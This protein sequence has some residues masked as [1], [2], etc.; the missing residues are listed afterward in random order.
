MAEKITARKVV[1]IYASVFVGDFQYRVYENGTVEVWTCSNFG[2]E[3]AFHP[4]EEDEDEFKMVQ[5]IGLK[6]LRG[7][8]E[9]QP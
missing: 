5:E 6:C 4:L 3:W 7:E 1:E 2:G 9:C 8:I